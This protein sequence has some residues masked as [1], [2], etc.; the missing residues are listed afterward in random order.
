MSQP[1]PDSSSWGISEISTLFLLLVA[2]TVAAIVGYVVLA[3]E[4]VIPNRPDVV[5]GAIAAVKPALG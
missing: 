1:G 5:G 2:V 4:G 3:P